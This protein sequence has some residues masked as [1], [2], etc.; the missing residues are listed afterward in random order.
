MEKI[1]MIQIKSEWMAGL[2][3]ICMQVDKFRFVL[4]SA[5]YVEVHQWSLLIFN[6]ASGGLKKVEND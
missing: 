3:N 1:W 2:V 4:F 6:F 5:S